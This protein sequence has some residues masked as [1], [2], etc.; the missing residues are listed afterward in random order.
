MSVDAAVHGLAL[1][2]RSAEPT[3]GWVLANVALMQ[4]GWFVCVLGAARGWPALGTAAVGAILLWHLWRTPY[5][6]REA[7]LI[8]AVLAL[9]A[10][11]DGTV[12]A[13]DAVA[14]PNGQWFAWLTPHWMLALWA[15][16]A[17]SLN[18]SLR[19][20]RQRWALAA[21]LGAVAGPLSYL[22]GVRLGA[23]RFI[24]EPLALALLGLGWAL[25]MPALLVLA[26]R[27]DGVAPRAG[28]EHVD[29]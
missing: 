15:L 1:P 18:V 24:D 6:R 26:E 16:F 11:F 3:R 23:A 10:V 19:W 13:A 27:F 2:A 25:T 9:G 14:Y 8:G 7:M 28:E 17:V 12:L 29:G 5:P 22:A 21:L 20:L 4:A